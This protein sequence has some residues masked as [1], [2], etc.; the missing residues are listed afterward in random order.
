[1]GTGTVDSLRRARHATPR[2]AAPRHATL[3]AVPPM[4]K[5]GITA[6]YGPTPPQKQAK[7]TPLEGVE[8]LRTPRGEFAVALSFE[9]HAAFRPESPICALSEA[10]GISWGCSRPHE[11]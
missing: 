2:H 8:L 9:A 3:M 5:H 6:V 10:A 4:P 1:M 7:F 11:P